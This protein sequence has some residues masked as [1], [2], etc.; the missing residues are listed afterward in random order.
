MLSV[1]IPTANEVDNEFYNQT[2]TQLSNLENVEVICVSKIEAHSRAQRLNLGFDRAQ[3]SMILFHHPRSV[4]DLAGIQY[5]IENANKKIWG[6]FT[7]EFD[8]RSHPLL[9][10]TS[11]YSNR[12]RGAGRGIFYL[13]HCIFFHRSLRTKVLPDIEIFE[14]TV[15]SQQLRSR[16]APL[17][18]PFKSTTSA[19]RF[20]KNGV[21]KQA[22]MNQV[23][24]LGF[25]L[26]LS[27]GM[28]NK[29]YEKNLNLNNQVD[30]KS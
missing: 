18:L 4:V 11:W 26:N 20:T 16:Q 24:K 28:M 6:A 9:K 3:G 19:V 27:D 30:K 12:M 1:I 25:L 10:F 5:L 22:F 8:Q 14:D 2:I 21:F 17:L 23:L 15:L 13:D 29:I 7:H